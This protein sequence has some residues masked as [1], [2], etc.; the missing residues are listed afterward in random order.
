MGV[1]DNT[2]EQSLTVESGSAAIID[3]PNIESEPP[4][5]VMWQNELGSLAYDH[6]YATTIKHQLVI[7]ATERDDAKA[8]Q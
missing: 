2:A 6:K 3:L 5:S 8:Y 1:F 7:L 4:P